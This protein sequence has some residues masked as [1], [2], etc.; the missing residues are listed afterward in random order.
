MRPFVA[1]SRGKQRGQPSPFNL[2]LAAEVVWD[3]A[4]FG[5]RVHIH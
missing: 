3:M 5:V 2:A 4:P 1:L